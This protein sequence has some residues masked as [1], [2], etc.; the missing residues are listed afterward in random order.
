MKNKDID[1]VTE[2]V[3]K[4]IKDKKSVHYSELYKIENTE[5]GII[6]LAWNRLSKD[7]GLITCSKHIFTLSKEG[8]KYKSVSLFL[9]RNNSPLI[10]YGTI[11]MAFITLMLGAITIYQNYDYKELKK[12]Y[13]SLESQYDSLNIEF[14]L[15]K[16]SLT[17][18]KYIMKQ[19]EK[20]LLQDTS[21][22]KN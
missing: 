15:Y 10:P 9:K 17:D 22:T 12:N 16:D 13:L 11:L 8:H 4:I 3:F 19:Q 20:M 7:Y 18:M 6:E 5:S 21:Q 2:E 1:Q 14:Q